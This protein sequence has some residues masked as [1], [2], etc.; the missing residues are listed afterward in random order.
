MSDTS[1]WAA[2]EAAI[3]AAMSGAPRGPIQM[4]AVRLGNALINVPADMPWPP[5]GLVMPVVERYSGLTID[6]IAGLREAL[7]GYQRGRRQKSPSASPSPFERLVEAHRRARA[8]GAGNREDEIAVVRREIGSAV[9]DAIPY[10]D[11]VA[12]RRAA[13]PRRL[14]GH[15]KKRR[16]V[17]LNG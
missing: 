4:K 2:I 15:P 7:E 3:R 16:L 8:A 1:G 9:Y 11:R 17:D 5:G 13:G 6:D 12:A 14:G 10:K